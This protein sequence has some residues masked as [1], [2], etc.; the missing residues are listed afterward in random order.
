MGS[1]EELF[2]HTLERARQA[3]DSRFPEVAG[4]A[5]F[6]QKGKN[7]RVGETINVGDQVVVKDPHPVQIAS[8]VT[9][10]QV[11]S[12]RVRI[13]GRHGLSAY[14]KKISVSQFCFPT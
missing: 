1:R 6:V 12:V 13:A 7:V 3:R 9:H 4:R 11:V 8:A 5:S 14:Y 10:E 2:S